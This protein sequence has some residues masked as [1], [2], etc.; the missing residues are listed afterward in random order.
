MLLACEANRRLLNVATR[1]MKEFRRHEMNSFSFVIVKGVRVYVDD[2]QHELTALS[3]SSL[4][5]LAASL[6]VSLWIS[7]N[8]HKMI[9]D[10]SSIFRNFPLPFITRA[11]A[12]FLVCKFTQPA[13]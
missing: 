2:V 13:S 8:L 10:I 5:K 7:V 4:N 11:L 3:I 6:D 1:Q 12:S 9:N